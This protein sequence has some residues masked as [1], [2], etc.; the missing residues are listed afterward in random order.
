MTTL[1][2]EI[3]K[4]IILNLP[5]HRYSNILRIKL[6]QKLGFINKNNND[7][8]IS[9]SIF[10]KGRVMIS[11]G[12]NISRNV[13]IAANSKSQILIGENSMIGPNTVIRSAN[14]KFSDLH[15]DMKFQGY[16]QKDIVLG[17]NCWIAA[18]CTIL[19]GAIIGDGCIVAAGAVVT[20]GSYPENAIL[21]GVPAK[22]IKT[23]G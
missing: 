10:I 18:N 23:R 20:S 5:D 8:F 4:M 1:L 16:E 2:K 6:F 12:V 13:T 21:A 19:P 14:H 15:I 9:T 11:N 17:R 7:F 22:I 3:V